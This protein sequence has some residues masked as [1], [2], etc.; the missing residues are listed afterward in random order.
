MQAIRSSSNLSTTSTYSQ[1]L[2]NS[3]LVDWADI[4]NGK[5]AA[6]DAY[7]RSSVDVAPEYKFSTFFSLFTILSILVD[8]TPDEDIQKRISVAFKLPTDSWGYLPF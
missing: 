7:D 4:E 8:E 1:V 2:T 3:I 5:A 6:A